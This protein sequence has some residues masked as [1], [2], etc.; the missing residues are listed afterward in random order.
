[1]QCGVVPYHTKQYELQVIL[2]IWNQE[3]PPRPGS[4]PDRLWGLVQCCCRIPPGERES[5][6][7]IL[8]CLHAQ[9]VALRSPWTVSTLAHVCVF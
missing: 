3:L 6:S 1:M 5:A 8:E 4:M 9:H 2:A 7:T